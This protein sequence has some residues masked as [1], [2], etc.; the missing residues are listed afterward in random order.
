MIASKTLSLFR[1]F[2]NGSLGD[3]AGIEQRNKI[4]DKHSRMVWTDAISGLLSAVNSFATR[5]REKCRHGGKKMTVTA[6]S[7][8]PIDMM[9]TTF[10]SE[11]GE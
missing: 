9:F 8:L 11:W 1:K 4:L 3:C 2:Q 5:E 7:N 6:R 10:I